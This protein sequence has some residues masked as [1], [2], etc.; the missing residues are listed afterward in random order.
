MG[1]TES[2]CEIGHY[3]FRICEIGHFGMTKYQIVHAARHSLR[4]CLAATN[5]NNQVT[6][7]AE[8]YREV[9]NHRIV[10]PCMQNDGTQKLP[11]ARGAPHGL[12]RV[13]H[14]RSGAVDAH[15]LVEY[16]LYCICNIR[17]GISGSL[18]ACQQD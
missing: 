3:A 16:S 14:L 11:R 8:V 18:R 1:K 7:S 13:W 15:N 5:N 6:S 10:A 17:V 2:I 4:E 12:V 9:V